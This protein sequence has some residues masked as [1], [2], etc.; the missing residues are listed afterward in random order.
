MKGPLWQL[1]KLE[2]SLVTLNEK[3]QQLSALQN[4]FDHFS[5]SNQVG[6]GILGIPRNHQKE[7]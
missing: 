4:N 7:K 6:R 5:T 3:F 2:L 1:S